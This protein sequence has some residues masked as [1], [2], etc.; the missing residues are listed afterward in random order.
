MNERMDKNDRRFGNNFCSA[1]QGLL[2]WIE[3][4]QLA[5]PLKFPGE[6]GQKRA[7]I[8]GRPS[9]DPFMGDRGATRA[10]KYLTGAVTR[11]LPSFY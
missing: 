8:S 10:V 5:L 6:Q 1:A 2:P 9:I 7:R 11:L 3:R 4:R